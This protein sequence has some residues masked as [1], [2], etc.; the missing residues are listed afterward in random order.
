MPLT[1]YIFP[2]AENETVIGYAVDINDRLVEG[3]VVE[4]DVA[5]AVFEEEVREKRSGPSII[6]QVAGNVFKTRIYPLRPGKTRTIKV[7]EIRIRIVYDL[8]KG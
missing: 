6:E 2:L 4:K 7:Q 5:R 3:V 1:F 8:T